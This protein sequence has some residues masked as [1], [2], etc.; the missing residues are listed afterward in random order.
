MLG[1]IYKHQ[2][3]LDKALMAYKSVIEI[4]PEHIEAR[5][6]LGV[7]YAIQEKYDSAITEWE[8]VLIIDPDNHSAA[9]NIGK[10]KEIMNQN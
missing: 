7:I 9:D 3:L 6:N 2:S 5:N 8:N 10:A 1:N 4:N